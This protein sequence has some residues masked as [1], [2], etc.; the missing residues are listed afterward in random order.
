MDR[1]HVL[2]VGMNSHLHQVDG[3]YFSGNRKSVCAWC[4]SLKLLSGCSVPLVCSVTHCHLLPFRCT[5]YVI[6]VCYQ[7]ITHVLLFLFAFWMYFLVSKGTKNEFWSKI[8]AGRIF[9]TSDKWK[10]LSS[11]SIIAPGKYFGRTFIVAVVVLSFCFS[12]T[13]IQTEWI[14]QDRNKTRTEW[15]R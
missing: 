1:R 11:S 5:F 9:Y 10:K 6:F 4:I 7:N 3:R 15:M 12:L 2:L 8:G 13:F 14:C